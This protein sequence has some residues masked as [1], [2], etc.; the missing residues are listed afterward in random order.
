MVARE[1]R[2]TV[3]RVCE[4]IHTKQTQDGGYFFARVPP[5]S[6]LDSYFAVRTL[7]MLGR[8]CKRPAAL[9]RFV[10]SFVRQGL[11]NNAHSLYLAMGIIQALGQ[12]TDL[13]SD[14]SEAVAEEL[15]RWVS[16]YSVDGIYIEVA[17]ELEAAY[18]AT[19]ALARLGVPLP[20]KAI[21]QFISSFR[22]K[23]G[24]FGRG[25]RSTL[26]TTHYAIQTFSELGLRVDEPQQVVAF[27]RSREDDIYFLEDLYYLVGALC[28]LGETPLNPS[29]V[30]SFVLG[31]RRENGGF[32]RG[33]PIG[34]PTLEYTY[35]AVSVLKQMGFLPGGNEHLG[36][37]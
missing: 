10:E 32:A 14:T 4:Y 23:D 9:R 5:G 24:G 13:L 8:C 33:V 19:W 15:R 20:T 22:N 2:D 29:G 34:I 3:R 21:T 35:Y 31:C 1:A 12:G 17:S 6:L 26:A 11:V 37:F 28:G 18:E 16:E 30:V 36:R 7:Q 27:L 25:A